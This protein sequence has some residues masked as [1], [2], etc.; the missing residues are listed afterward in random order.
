[1]P[2]KRHPKDP[3][4]T[5]TAYEAPDWPT[6][7]DAP[8]SRRRPTIKYVRI[9]P[10]ERISVL[11]IVMHAIESYTKTPEWIEELAALGI[12]QRDADRIALGVVAGLAFR[13][14]SIAAGRRRGNKTNHPR[15]RKKPY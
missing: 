12:K 15:K 3:M 2:N 13:C 14:E 4:I 9:A 6:L 1:M 8:N 5:N 11:E 10:K 7:P